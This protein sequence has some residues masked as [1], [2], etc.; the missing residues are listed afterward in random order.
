MKIHPSLTFEVLMDAAERRESCLDNPGFCIACG[1]ESDS[2]E[3]DATEYPCDA[4]GERKVYAP[5]ELLLL[6]L[7]L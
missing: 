4:C 2:S 5:E 6:E 3:P 7:G 1:E